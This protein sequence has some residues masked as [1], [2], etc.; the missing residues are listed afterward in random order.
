MTHFRLLLWDEVCPG[1][2]P[3]SLQQ[4]KGCADIV[5]IH[6][7]SDEALSFLILLSLYYIE[8]S[9]S[10]M[11]GRLCIRE[12]TL[13]LAVALRKR[14]KLLGAAEMLS[15]RRQQKIPPATAILEVSVRSRKKEENV[16]LWF[17]C[18]GAALFFPSPSLLLCSQIWHKKQ[19]HS[20]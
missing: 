8:Y 13:A 15:H 12:P 17:L 5:N 19:S 18:S 20:F 10:R 3:F 2:A 6:I 11:K 14:Q 9:C 1:S 4:L 7:W 16:W